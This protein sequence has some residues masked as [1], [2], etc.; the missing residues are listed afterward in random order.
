MDYSR[1]I[2]L[3]RAVLGV[4]QQDL[5]KTVELSPSLLSRI[6]A[7]ERT[8][9]TR[10]KAKIATHLKIPNSLIDLFGFEPNNNKVSEAELKKI[11]AAII[12]LSKMTNEKKIE[13]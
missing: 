11:G 1:S 5:A 6:E 7:G 9:S 2:R 13:I 8:L 4:S 12:K 10:N 3:L